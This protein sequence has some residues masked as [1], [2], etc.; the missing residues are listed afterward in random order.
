MDIND[1]KILFRGENAHFTEDLKIFSVM[2]PLLKINNKLHILFE[3]RSD[4]LSQPGEVSLPGGAVEKNEA[5]Y[6]AGI[7]EL[8]EEVGI[9]HEKVEKIA[10]LNYFSTPFN[11]IIYPFLVYIKDFKNSDLK[12]NYD[13]VSEIFFVPLDFF[14]NYSPLK[15]KVDVK[16]VPPENYPY[17]LIPNGKNYNWRKGFY[18][19]YFYIYKDKIIWGLTAKIIYNFIKKLP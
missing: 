12:L 10:Q 11:F 3:I 5:L 7:R 6:S 2:V 15:Y 18:K 8:E 14:I 1:I 13:E 9:T 19:T 17:H 4:K 16:M